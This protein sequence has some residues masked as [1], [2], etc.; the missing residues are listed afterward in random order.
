[1]TNNQ[2]ILIGIGIV[3]LG[4]YLYTKNKK[5]STPVASTTGTANT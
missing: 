1:M 4:Y 2:K 3:A 5:T